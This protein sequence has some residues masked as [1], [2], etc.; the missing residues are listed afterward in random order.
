VEDSDLLDG[1]DYTNFV[2]THSAQ[3]VAGIKTFSGANIFTA[4]NTFDR[5]TISSDI[6]RGTPEKGTV[7]KNSI[8]KAGARLNC[9]GTFAIAEGFNISG[10]ADDGTGEATILWDVDF[11]NA[12]T[13]Y[14]VGT[15]RFDGAGTQPQGINAQ[16]YAVGSVHVHF[17]TSDNT[18]RD[19]SE[20]GII[21]LGDQ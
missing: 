4:L 11:A 18:L 6:G 5:I 19:S 12:T 20:V 16:T 13:Y 17:A 8:I 1:L 14:V 7:Y 2:D 15:C 3:S 10:L 21:A 9:S